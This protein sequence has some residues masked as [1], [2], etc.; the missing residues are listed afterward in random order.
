MTIPNITPFEELELE[1]AELYEQISGVTAIENEAQHEAVTDLRKAIYEAGK[2]A[3]A[4]LA[5]NVK[6]HQDAEKAERAKFDPL[7]GTAKTRGIGKVPRG[8]QV[9][10]ELLTPYRKRIADEKAA[11]ARKAAEEAEAERLAAIEAMRASSGDIEAR[12]QAEQLLSSAEQ[13]E[14]VAKRANKEAT[15]GLGLRTVWTAEIVDQRAAVLSAMKREPE[16][17]LDLALTIGKRAATSGVREMGG[18]RIYS[19]KVAR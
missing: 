15:T 18:F 11:A 14:R 6:P 7:I 9:L 17:F 13:A 16:A 3:E 2:R 10:D 19:E 12:E 8:I 1:I 4:L 5:E